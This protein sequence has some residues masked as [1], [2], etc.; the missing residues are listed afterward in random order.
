MNRRAFCRS[1]GATLV[2]VGAASPSRHAAEIPRDGLARVLGL[3]GA[4]VA[5]LDDLSAA[6]QR[7]L[8]SAL[9]G[10]RPLARGT[11][12]LLYTVIGRRERLFQYVGYPPLP[13]RLI[14]CDGLLRD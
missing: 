1:L 3:R 6:Q 12:N 8:W 5:W 7:E 11:I 2:T 9:A 13:N 4:E 14:A 10:P